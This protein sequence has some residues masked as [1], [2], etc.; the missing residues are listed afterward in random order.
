[1]QR[2][3]SDNKVPTQTFSPLRITSAGYSYHASSFFEY[4]VA[5]SPYPGRQNTPPP[6]YIKRPNSAPLSSTAL[7]DCN[8]EATDVYISPPLPTQP[9]LP[10]PP[11]LI[12]AARVASRCPRPPPP[13]ASPKALLDCNSAVDTVQDTVDPA[14]PPLTE[15][16]RPPGDTVV[17]LQISFA[18]KSSGMGA[19]IGVSW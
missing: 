17:D 5:G 14:F 9:P 8:S 7:S 4:S 2:G 19:P 1:M 10:R 16:L 3:T 12:L 15:K 11:T 18:T 13:P 6:E